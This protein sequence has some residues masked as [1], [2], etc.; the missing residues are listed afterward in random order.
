MPAP[1]LQM[2]D[3]QLGDQMEEVSGGYVFSNTRPW[4]PAQDLGNLAAPWPANEGGTAMNSPWPGTGMDSFPQ[5]GPS[6]ARMYQQPMSHENSTTI[7]APSTAPPSQA[8]GSCCAPQ[9]GQSLPQSTSHVQ[10]LTGSA[11]GHDGDISMG[12]AHFDIENNSMNAAFPADASAAADADYKHQVHEDNTIKRSMPTSTDQT[13]YSSVQYGA[14]APN[15]FAHDARPSFPG[16]NGYQFQQIMPQNAVSGLIGSM[17]PSADCNVVTDGI[18]QPSNI[19]HCGPN[20]Q[21]VYCSAHPYNEPTRTRIQELTNIVDLDMRMNP[22]SRPQSQ[23]GELPTSNESVLSMMQN[24]QTQNGELS[25]NLSMP[26]STLQPNFNSGLTSTSVNGY[27][28]LAI[29]N[30][31]FFSTGYQTMEYTVKPNCGDESGICG[32]GDDCTCEGCTYHIGNNPIPVTE[33]RST[34]FPVGVELTKI[35]VIKD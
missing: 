35:A 7:P 28:A 2:V 19:C 16:E 10:T 31:Y 18:S 22:D 9:P 4:P 1:D 13:D 26:E 15:H 27:D 21:C 8:P 17:A 30:G 5:Q 20:C 23:Y 32:C 29:Q 12:E 6:V 11:H 3:S 33:V 24:L 34:G 25:T 14:T